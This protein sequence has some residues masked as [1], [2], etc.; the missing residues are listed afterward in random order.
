VNRFGRGRPQPGV[1]DD[2]SDRAGDC[3]I[4]LRSGSK[5]LEGRSASRE[6]RFAVGG[7]AADPMVGRRVQHPATIEEEQAVEVVGNHED[8]TRLA[9]AASTRRQSDGNIVTL[10]VDSPIAYDGG[11]I[12]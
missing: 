5:A 2:T 1:G 8:G 7:N 4:A 10:G 3:V 6:S 9:L 11:A 12:F